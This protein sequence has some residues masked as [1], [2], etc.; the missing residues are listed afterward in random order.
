MDKKPHLYLVD[1][2]G[3]IYRAYHA[4]PPLKRRDGTPMGAIYGFCTMLLKLLTE[5]DADALAVILDTGKPTFR[6]ALYPLYKSQRREVPEDL[7]PQFPLIRDAC[8][9]FNVPTVELEGFEADDLIASYSQSARR[10][11]YRTTI[12]SSDKDLMQ[13]VTTDVEMW[14]PIKNKI[15]QREQVIEKFGV[16]PE[17]IIDAQA[18]AGDSSD[19]VPGVPGIGPKT[20]AEL[21]NTFGDLDR[22]LESLPLIKQEKRRQSLMD[23]REMALLSRQLVTLDAQ[24]PLPK[25]LE[26]L[27]KQ[28]LDFQKLLAFFRLNDFSS[29]ASKIQRTQQIA[30]P[31]PKA[32][33]TV[34]SLEALAPWLQQAQTKGLLCI[35]CETTSLDPHQAQLVGIAL[36]LAP[37]EACYIPL[38]HRLPRSQA[39]QEESTQGLLLP[40][41]APLPQIPLAQALKALQPILAD[42]SVLKIGHNLKYDLLVLHKYGLQVNPIEDTLLMSYA[43]DA[44]QNSHGLDELAERHL[45]HTTIRFADVVGTGKNQK[46]FD[47]VPLDQATAYAAEDADVTFALY[48]LLRKRLEEEHLLTLYERLDRPLV[49]VLVEMEAMG[50]QVD[51]QMLKTLGTEFTQRLQALESLIFKEVGKSFNLASPKQLGGI[52]FEEMNLPAPKKTKTGMYTT[53]SD[54]LESLASQGFSIAQNILDWRSLFKLNSTYVEGLLAAMNPKTQRIHTSY[55]L[56][57]TLTGRLSSSNPNLQN[58]PI[59]TEDGK[60]IRQAFIASKGMQLL[61]LDYSQVELKVLAHMADIT[62]LIEAF[63]QGQDIHQLTASQVFGVPLSKVD[64]T[65]RRH[66]KAIN[67]GIIYGMSPY[68]LAQ[69]LGVAQTVAQQ[70]IQAYFARYP[71][72]QDY[73]ENTKET[74]RSKGYVETFWGRRIYIPRI[75]DANTNLKKAAERQAINAPIQG[76]SADIIKRAMVKVPKALQNQRL[77]ARLL[78]QVHDELVFEVPESELDVT[79]PVLKEVMEKASFL[80][81]PLTVD[82]VVGKS[83]S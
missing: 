82:V 9:A 64:S 36:A 73:M 51:P 37:G 6:H 39:N 62:P 25:P 52:L 75:N 19:N 18:L 11:G 41:A 31:A 29:L 57:S 20:A 42:P 33:E 61:S 7:L 71:G 16:P 60:R 13:L 32:Y 4:L 47:Q 27:E 56:A 23:H 17:K 67:F 38:A 12:V 77:S 45:H 68:G 63:C 28:P 76:S 3:F 5:T 79:I 30:P 46:T 81:A 22:L 80:K 48:Q 15:I 59:K 24:T 2:S 54:T 72:I 49:P 55:S 58:I 35:D 10:L 50:I 70:Y 8:A 53:D 66:A 78:L 83:W 1:G 44:G 34:Q 14:D 65:L 43:C 74:A 21:L 69:Q 40:L 26:V